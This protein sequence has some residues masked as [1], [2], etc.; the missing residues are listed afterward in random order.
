MLEGRKPVPVRVTDWPGSSAAGLTWVRVG[1][2]TVKS[3][4]LTVVPQV[5]TRPMRPVTAP[6][7]T[8]TWRVLAF[9]TVKLVVAT[10]PNVTAVMRLAAKFAPLTVTTVLPMLP[11][12][13]E[14]PLTLTVHAAA[15]VGVVSEPLA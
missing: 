5:V 8:V 3:E 12:A 2:F 4:G 7:G 1:A 11:L 10:P 13:G 14:M 6:S 15:V 9:T